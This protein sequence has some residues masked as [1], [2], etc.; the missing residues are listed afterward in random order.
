ML[1]LLDYFIEYL[2]L[3]VRA[4]GFQ[5]FRQHLRA[6]GLIFEPFDIDFFFHKSSIKV[7][8]VIHYQVELFFEG[9]CG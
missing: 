7:A 1:G 4:Q 3:L 6:Y 2:Y 8:L 5:L 9:I